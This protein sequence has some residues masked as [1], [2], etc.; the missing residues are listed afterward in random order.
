MKTV[1]NPLG[2]FLM[3]VFGVQTMF[4]A[5]KFAGVIEKWAVALCP[6]W[7]LAGAAV[8]ALVVNGLASLFAYLEDR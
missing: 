1:W 7:F 8:Y 5:L 2:I 6:A 3:F 4:A